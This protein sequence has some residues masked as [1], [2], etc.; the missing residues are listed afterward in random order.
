MPE[1]HTS[2]ESRSVADMDVTDIEPIDL[3]G[4][5]LE[6]YGWRLT[7]AIG[8]EHLDREDMH[9]EVFNRG[10]EVLEIGWVWDQDVS[11]PSLRLC[12]PLDING[13]RWPVF[14]PED[15][16]RALSEDRQ[17]AQTVPAIYDTSPRRDTSTEL[18]V[19]RR[20]IA[21]EIAD[22][23]SEYH[24][25]ATD[26]GGE[27]TRTLDLDPNLPPWAVDHDGMVFDGPPQPQVLEPGD[28]DWPPWLSTAPLWDSPSPEES[29]SSDA[30]VVDRAGG[31]GREVLASQRFAAMDPEQVDAA[32]GLLRDYPDAVPWDEVERR[33]LTLDQVSLVYAADIGDLPDVATTDP[34]RPPRAGP[35]Q[36]ATAT[37]ETGH[38]DPRRDLERAA[39][40]ADVVPARGGATTPEHLGAGTD[41]T[42]EGSNGATTRAALNRLVDGEIT[43]D[44]RARI[45][46]TREQYPQLIDTDIDAGL[47]RA[48]SASDEASTLDDGGDEP[49]FDFWRDVIGDDIVV[50]G[51]VYSAD[52]Y[53]PDGEG[54]VRRLT[55]SELDMHPVSSG[56]SAADQL[57]RLRERLADV[58]ETLHAS[59]RERAP[60]VDASPP[61]ALGRQVNPD[62]GAGSD[63]SYG[64]PADA[65][66]ADPRYQ[67][68]EINP[69]PNIEI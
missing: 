7:G 66:S 53:T 6:E 27:D 3:I 24:E 65:D 51:V 31:A 4:L 14:T 61:R 22:F 45:G 44:D 5:D 13:T 17:L 36:P 63:L 39:D 26:V 33:G 18:Y 29:L 9:V 42:D 40:A 46:I 41:G 58:R 59:A 37:P 32:R 64:Y 2:D 56:H 52:L 23:R 16:A 20:R 21:E 57:D 25:P 15:V 49:D 10:D 60:T 35:W 38:D 28:P 48:A 1:S 54:G 11:D 43:D 12:S 69:G 67:Q 30:M 62:I 68:S 47:D 34:W 55:E 50:G 19:Y 8:R